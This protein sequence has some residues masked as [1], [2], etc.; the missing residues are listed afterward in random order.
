LINTYGNAKIKV[1]VVDDDA[2]VMAV[3]KKILSDINFTMIGFS[4]ENTIKEYLQK[5][6]VDIIMTDL[7]IANASGIDLI[8]DIK[9]M[10]SKNAMAPIIA[11]TGDSYM[12]SIEL[13]SIQADELIIK[14]INREEL[15]SKLLKVLQ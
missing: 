10:D 12:N 7:Q 9:N 3:V 15:Y 11:I 4:S 1:A 5:E 14:P 2:M 8:K 13:S 6:T